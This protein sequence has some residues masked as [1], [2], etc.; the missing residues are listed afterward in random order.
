MMKKTEK[1]LNQILILIPNTKNER[2]IAI[3]SKKKLQI[4]QIQKPDI[5]FT[6]IKQL[7]PAH[8][9]VGRTVSLIPLITRTG[10]EELKLDLQMY[11]QPKPNMIISIIINPPAQLIGVRY[12][13]ADTALIRTASVWITAS[14]RKV[15]RAFQAGVITVHIGAAAAVL[16]SGIRT[17]LIQNRMFPDRKHSIDIMTRRIPIIFMDG[18]IG[19]IGSQPPLSQMMTEMFR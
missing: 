18:A 7:I 2:Y 19:A 16:I 3:K 9:R 14:Q 12:G 13:T 11:I 17:E 8:G 15:I 6:E 1:K 4:I 5:S 10:Q